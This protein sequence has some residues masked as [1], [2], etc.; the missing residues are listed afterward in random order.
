MNEQSCAPWWSAWCWSW[1]ARPN[2]A[3]PAKAAPVTAAAAAGGCLDDITETDLRRQYLVK[4]PRNGPA[5]PGFEA[6]HPRPA[7][8]GTGGRPLSDPYPCCACG[9][10]TRRRRTRCFP[11]W[12][13][14]LWK[15]NGFVPVQ[16]L[17]QNKDEYLTRPR[18]GP[19]ADE[20]N[21]AIIKRPWA[22]TQK[23]FWR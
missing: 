1:R 23:W 21:Q 20:A 19:P 2:A 22:R 14:P 10:T 4:N 11:T 7:G 3:A 13:T 15:K 16:T 5:F 17:C 9:P 6:A 18:P 12:T 8:P